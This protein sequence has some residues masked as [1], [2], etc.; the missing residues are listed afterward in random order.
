[1]LVLWFFRDIF[2]ENFI[3]VFFRFIKLTFVSVPVFGSRN[4][5]G[6]VTFPSSSITYLTVYDVW[7][8]ISGSDVVTLSKYVKNVSFCSTTGR[9]WR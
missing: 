8:N 1:M 5:S 3:L 9:Y 4:D 2:C 6:F 7:P